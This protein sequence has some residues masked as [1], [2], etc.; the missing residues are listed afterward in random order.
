MEAGWA[1]MKPGMG[2]RPVELMA[3][4]EQAGRLRSLGQFTAPDEL[5]LSAFGSQTL[6]TCGVDKIDANG[7]WQR[8]WQNL[9][10]QHK[11][12]SHK[13]PGWS[14]GVNL[15]ALVVPIRDA[16]ADGSQGLLQPLL[17]GV[18]ARTCPTS[19]FSLPAVKAV[20][21]F[22]WNTWAYRC[23]LY[24]LGLFVVWLSFYIAFTLLFEEETATEPLPVIASTTRGMATLAC[25]AAALLSMLPFMW[26][27]A[28]TLSAYHLKGWV[29][30]WNL[31]DIASYLL[32][33]VI[34]FAHWDRRGVAQ[35]WFPVILS[36]Q[37]VVL[38]TKLHFFARV[39][40][41]EGGNLVLDGLRILTEDLRW[42]LAFL[43]LTIL[44]F[45]F[46]FYSLF[47]QDRED[48][49]DFSNFWHAVAS[50]VSYITAMF[51]MN[52]FYNA[53]NPVA[54]ILLFFAFE[55]VVYILLLNIMIAIMASSFSKIGK[56]DTV[57]LTLHKA[58]I[59]DELATTLPKW[60][61]RREWTPPFIHCLSQVHPVS[62]A[63]EPAVTEVMSGMEAKLLNSNQDMQA[64]LD[65]LQTRVEVTGKQVQLL[66]NLTAELASAVATPAAVQEDM[67]DDVQPGGG[68]HF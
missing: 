65:V 22:K 17:K 19:V 55:F 14:A 48:G 5:V 4:L 53:R 60:L 34:T 32:Q 20:V 18:T 11:G 36:V 59:I 58:Q 29:N 23:L 31:L 45:A 40:S 68:G 46:A 35:T 3:W 54:S 28:C 51:D 26:M 50:M 2:E 13:T 27:E 44:G 57:R 1:N 21:D 63:F 64:R 33:G 56:D 16:A 8:M 9:L 15:E 47:R 10:L 6:L 25:S 30:F 52:I 7:M 38:F 41:P 42:F 37:H 62:A 24:E 12:T 43:G 66:A 67:R 39:L 49:S 61:K